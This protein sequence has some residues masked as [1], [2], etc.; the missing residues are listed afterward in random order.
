MPS[1]S[2][3]TYGIASVSTVAAADVLVRGADERNIADHRNELVADVPI[4]EVELLTGAFLQELHVA[5]QRF[6][7]IAD[8]SEGLIDLLGDLKKLSAHLANVERAEAFETLLA[9]F[10]RVIVNGDVAELHHAAD[11]LAV[12]FADDAFFLAGGDEGVDLLAGAKE[13]FDDA[14]EVGLRQ[15]GVQINPFALAPSGGVGAI[16]VRTQ[17]GGAGPAAPA[18]DDGPPRGG[19]ASTS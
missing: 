7:Q 16:W 19:R 11:E 6:E 1:E 12:L 17:P 5:P 9:D 14:V 13:L 15:Q 8:P 2:A 10:D 3:N 4:D 18:G